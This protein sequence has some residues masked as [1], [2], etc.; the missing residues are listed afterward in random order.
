MEEGRIGR[1]EIITRVTGSTS[2]KL[3]FLVFPQYICLQYFHIWALTHQKN[4]KKKLPSPFPAKVSMFTAWSYSPFCTKTSK[5]TCT[6]PKVTWLNDH[7]HLHNNDPSPQ[8]HLM[9]T[10][11]LLWLWSRNDLNRTVLPFIVAMLAVIL[12]RP[13]LFYFI[14]LYFGV[15]LWGVLMVKFVSGCVLGLLTLQMY[16]RMATSHN[17]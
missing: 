16:V 14:Q 17:A 2:S 9:S 3:M 15:S 10:T 4:T 7:T 11:A 13:L 6:Y 5:I 12:Y 1:V 8:I